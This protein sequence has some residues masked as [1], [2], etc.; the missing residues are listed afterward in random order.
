MVL[1][2]PV[3]LPALSDRHFRNAERPAV[4]SLC[5]I[6]GLGTSNGMGAL[7][8]LFADRCGV[9]PTNRLT[10][11]RLINLFTMWRVQAR[12]EIGPDKRK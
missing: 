9:D 1:R 2:K 10:A 5:G 11:R 12:S 8:V 7:L 4:G 6:V 3:A